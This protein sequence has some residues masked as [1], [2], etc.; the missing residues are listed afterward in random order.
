MTKQQ[1]R[2]K[3]YSKKPSNFKHTRQ[4]AHMRTNAPSPSDLSHLEAICLF[5][6]S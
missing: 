5:Q 3:S 6:L 2:N 4:H 1:L